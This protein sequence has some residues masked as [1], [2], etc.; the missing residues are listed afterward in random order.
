[1]YTRS[2]NLWTQQVKLVG[3]GIIGFAAQG[4]SVS[5][6]GDG[7]T[8]IVGGSDDNDFTGATW[9]YTRSE[10]GW[11]QQAKLV[12]TGAIGTFVEQGRSVSLSD[13]GNTAIVGGPLDN[14]DTGLGVGAAWVFRRSGGVWTQQAK[15]VGTGNVGDARQGYSVSL[16]G[17]G[18]TTLVGGPT[19]NNNVGAAWVFTQ[20]V[21]AGTPSNA[22]CR[23]WPR[24]MAGSITPQ[25]PWIALVKA[26]EQPVHPMRKRGRFAG[27]QGPS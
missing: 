18:S 19:D 2:G 27:H 7:N 25:Q 12:G 13:G 3:T 4:I 14:G 17:D 24:N 6:S 16:S 20:P 21:F 15:L 22:N 9:V 10:K 1:V 8:A 11:T 23:R 5:L 26:P